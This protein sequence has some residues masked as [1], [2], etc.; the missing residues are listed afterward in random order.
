M[1]IKRVADH[2][3]ATPRVAAAVLMAAM[4]GAPA[5]AQAPAAEAPSIALDALPPLAGEAPVVAEPP[6]APPDTSV[7]DLLSRPPPEPEELFGY[8]SVDVATT[9]FDEQ[10][11]RASTTPWPEG[12]VTLDAFVRQTARLPVRMRV[13]QVNRWVNARI[14][15]ASDIDVYGVADYWASLAEVMLH[16]RGDCEDFAIAK[17]QILAAAGVP[18]RDMYLTL[19]RD[20]RR[21]EDHAVLVVR[22]GQDAYVLDSDENT[23][24]RQDELTRFRPVVAFSEN[25]RWIFGHRSKQGE[26]EMAAG[27]PDLP[28]EAPAPTVASF[29]PGAR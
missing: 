2:R 23:L 21:Q 4:F 13:D 18:T 28:P 10:W 6:A 15:Y 29:S 16:G 9:P 7:D 11:L 3:R 22:V 25:G 24:L 14:A 5:L 26:A 8:L 20:L 27:V 17:M 1:Q 19:V 12:N